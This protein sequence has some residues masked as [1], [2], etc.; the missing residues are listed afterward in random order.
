[1]VLWCTS[2]ETHVPVSRAESGEDTDPLSVVTKELTAAGT[3]VTADVGVGYNA[4]PLDRIEVQV[5][6]VVSTFDT[7]SHF[8]GVVRNKLASTEM[9]GY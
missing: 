9:G 3:V 8:E 1:M 5:P 4:G 6:A 2:G 7:N